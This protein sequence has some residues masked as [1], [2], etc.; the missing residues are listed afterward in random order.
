MDRVRRLGLPQRVVLVAAIGAALLA[1]DAYVTN[2]DRFTGWTGYAPL[3]NG[4]PPVGGLHPWVQLVVRLALVL[5]WAALSLPLLG[6]RRTGPATEPRPPD[7]PRP[8]A[9]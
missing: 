2:L 5:V 1:V 8:D 9:R 7:R 4:A 3:T 6:A